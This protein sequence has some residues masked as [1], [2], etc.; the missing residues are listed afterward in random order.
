MRDSI[1][2]YKILIILFFFFAA[3]RDHKNN[4]TQ[5]KSATIVVSDTPVTSSKTIAENLLTDS[6]YSMFAESLK[7]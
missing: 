3:C 2:Y 7:A 1:F 6:S 4:D 5:V